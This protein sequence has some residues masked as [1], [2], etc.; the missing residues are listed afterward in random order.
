[1][2]R[3][4]SGKHSK[5]YQ[6]VSLTVYFAKHLLNNTP[7]SRLHSMKYHLPKWETNRKHADGEWGCCYSVMTSQFITGLYWFE[8]VYDCWMF[9]LLCLT[10][11]RN[12]F[13]PSVLSCV[14]VGRWRLFCLREWNCQWRVW[15]YKLLSVVVFICL[16][17]ANV[18]GELSNK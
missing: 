17:P 13:L 1:M 8:F 5:I 16:W 7:D 11:V 14:N 2:M 4:E 6:F 18:T 3:L 12:L 9:L 15:Y 10:E